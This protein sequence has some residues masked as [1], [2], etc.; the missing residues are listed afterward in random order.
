M[1]I[2]IGIDFDDTLVPTRDALYDYFNK[3]HGT[4]LDPNASSVFRCSQ[5]WGYT[6]HGF[7]LVFTAEQDFFHNV[8]RP[9]PGVA[10]VL[11][12]WVQRATLHVVT[13]RPPEWIPSAE[14][15]CRRHEL[16]IASVCCADGETKENKARCA[17]QMGLK[18]FVEDSADSAGRIADAGID[19]L[20]LDRPYNQG[21]SHSRV[22]RVR[23]WQEIAAAAR[24]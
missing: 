24:F 4:A 12:R 22:T 19:V 10:E 14:S 8:M 7:R 1:S 16:P 2:H 23:D 15:F 17:Q 5:L 11:A 13:A 6:G 3:K 18:L 21:F 20:L 9:Y